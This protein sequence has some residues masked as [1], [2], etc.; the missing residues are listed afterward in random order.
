MVPGRDDFMAKQR[1]PIQRRFRMAKL[2]AITSGRCVYCGFEGDLEVDHIIPLTKG[3]SGADSNLVS[4]CRDC[5]SSK[6]NYD[7]PHFLNHILG[8]KADHRSIKDNSNLRRLIRY[9][10]SLSRYVTRDTVT[11]TLTDIDID[12]DLDKDKDYFE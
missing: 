9:D 4:A 10:E 3:G 11:V 2:L 12:K 8:D 1:R 5:N 7:L 6:N